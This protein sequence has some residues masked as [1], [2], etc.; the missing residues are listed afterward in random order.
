MRQIL[1]C[2]L[3][4]GS[5]TSLLAYADSPKED[6][7]TPLFDGKTLKGWEGK[8]GMFRVED[9]AVVAGTL[10]EKIPNNEF[11]CT[12]KTYKN[13]E[14]RLKAKL[15]GEGANAGVQ[16]RTKRIPNHHE[17]SGYQC[18]MGLMGKDNIWG[19][20]YDESRRKKF[21]VIGPQEAVQKAVK[22]NDWNDFVIRCEGP[23]IQ[24]WVNG[25]Q[26]VD[27]TEKEEGIEDSGIIA[28]Q[29]HGGPASEASYRDV[30]IKELK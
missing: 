11:L 5:L 15:V 22:L 6:G 26:T 14:L 29:I 1:C 30:R 19:S 12:E 27:Y 3:L 8:Q 13:F 20:L 24:L 18:D 25:V 2:M 21:L 23:H 28:L 9:G 7:F 17:V 4:I 16:F 10:K